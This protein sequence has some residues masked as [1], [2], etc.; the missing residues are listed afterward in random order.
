[1]TAGDTSIVLDFDD[2]TITKMRGS[3]KSYQPGRY[4]VRGTLTH[5]AKVLC[6]EFSVVVLDVDECALGLDNCG[7]DAQ[8]VNTEGSFE[9]QTRED[10]RSDSCL[11]LGAKT[12]VL[13]LLYPCSLVLF[14]EMCGVGEQENG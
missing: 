1:M 13:S 12:C 4:R 10:G 3:S 6:V 5:D 8:C 14:I 9:C 11:H 7:D 2:K